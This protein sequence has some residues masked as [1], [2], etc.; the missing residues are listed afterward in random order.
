MQILAQ[1][2]WKVGDLILANVHQ[3]ALGESIAINRLVVF[4]RFSIL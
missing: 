3:V 1:F 2:F 4:S